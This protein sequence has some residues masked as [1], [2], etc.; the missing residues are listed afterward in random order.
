V[1]TGVFSASLSRRRRPALAS[2][3]A[4]MAGHQIFLAAV[5]VAELRYGSLVAGWGTRRERREATIGARTVVPVTNA[6]LTRVAELR[7]VSREAAHP[8]HER[9]HASDLWIAASAM[10]IGL[11]S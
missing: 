11:R 4:L 5:T 7:L 10:H 1:D 6:L 3:V 9:A 2:K 8:L